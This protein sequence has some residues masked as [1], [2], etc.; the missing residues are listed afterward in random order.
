MGITQI[1]VH[2]NNGQ[3]PPGINDDI[4][5]GYMVDSLWRDVVNTEMYVCLDPSAGAAVWHQIT[6]TRDE[7]FINT[8]TSPIYNF[9]NINDITR[10]DTSSSNIVSNLKQASS[11]KVR[12]LTATKIVLAGE[13]TFNAFPGE[14][15]MG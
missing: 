1:T 3:G 8:I 7:I 5:K 6:Y 11:S 12:K 2:N 10:F 13:L 15:V 9:D 14:T 4:V